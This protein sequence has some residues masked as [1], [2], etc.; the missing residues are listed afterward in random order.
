[1]SEAM[2]GATRAMGAMNR[3]MNLPALQKIMREFEVQNERMEM[4]SEVMGDAVDD[5]FEVLAAPPCSARSCHF[6]SEICYKS[7]MAVSGG[8]P[9]A[10]LYFHLV[11]IVVVA[12]G[13]GTVMTCMHPF[14]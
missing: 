1:M 14:P 8:G 5:V 11:A 13:I 6:A 12:C 9:Y 2:K 7:C 3:Q 10:M 4:T